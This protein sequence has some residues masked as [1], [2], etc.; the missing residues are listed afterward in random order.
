MAKEKIGI[1]GGTFNPI[2]NGHVAMAEAAQRAAGLDRVL[3]LPD[4]V[5]PHKTGIAPAEDRWR[6][7]CAAVWNHAGLE[8]CRAELDREGTTYSFDTLTNLHS[9]Y[10]RAELYFIIGTD[11]LMQLKSWHRWEEVLRLCTFLV[12][13]RTTAYRP[14]EINAER[15]RLT[16]LGGRFQPVAM[17][18]INVSSTELRDA[19]AAGK[20]TPLLHPAVREY[21]LL[22]GFY[23]AEPG[24][25]EAEGWLAELFR[26]LNRHRF[27]HSL[28]VAGTARMLARI[29]GVSPEKAETAALL[30]DCAKCMPLREMQRV[31]AERRLTEDEFILGSSAMLH[32]PVG[33]CLCREV[34]GVEDP[35]IL[36]AI[37]CHTTGQAG[38]SKLDLIVWLADKIEPTREARPEIV[39]GRMMA[40]LSLEK[41]TL[42]V[43]EAS[44]AYVMSRGR[45]M[46][47]AT[48]DAIAWLK[49][50]IAG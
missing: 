40:P 28:C 16:A 46:H 33:A 9:L 3:M 18:V 19:I 43:M 30:H 14:E 11:T 13:P 8:P 35:E 47:P 48:M 1:M 4:R 10:P 31:A 27:V 26:T 44:A 45:G 42:T 49:Q 23:G 20:P 38:M 15:K 50:E 29:H 2:H 24:C 21:C 12:C 22:R 25:A 6:M 17:P 32:A 41:A 37:A 5:P 7:V 36:H 34:Y 39:K